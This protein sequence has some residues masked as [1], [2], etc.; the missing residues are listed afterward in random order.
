MDK[1][2]FA[3]FVQRPRRIEDLMAPHLLERERPYEVVRVVT[4]SKIDYENFVTDM[5]ADRQ[6]LEDSVSLCARGQSWRCLLIRQRG[7]AEG[8]LVMPST[9][10]FVDWA[11]VICL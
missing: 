10:G 5:L 4:L 1:T 11:A 7:G 8:V 3:F 6:F 9:G 2:G